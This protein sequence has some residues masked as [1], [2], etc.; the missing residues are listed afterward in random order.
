MPKQEQAES[1]LAAQS[2]SELKLIVASFD[3]RMSFY[4][5]CGK[6]YSFFDATPERDWFNVDI[7]QVQAIN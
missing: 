2:F 7:I 6:T 3:T 1:I 4:T 5:K